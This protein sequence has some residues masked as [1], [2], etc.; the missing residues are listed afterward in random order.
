VHL[1]R[2]RHRQ[3]WL[4][5]LQSKATEP[6]QDSTDVAVVIT[7]D[8]QHPSCCNCS[9]ELLLIS[10]DWVGHHIASAAGSRLSTSTI[11]VADITADATYVGTDYHWSELGVY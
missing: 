4:H 8:N 1:D 7:I 10:A 3:C 9:H 2:L 11:D 5:F 6:N